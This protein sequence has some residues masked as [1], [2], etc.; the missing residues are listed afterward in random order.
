MEDESIAVLVTGAERRLLE[1]ET[2]RDPA[3]LEDLLHE[4]FREIGRSGRLWTRDELIDVMTGPDAVDVQSAVVTGEHVELVG[5]DLALLTYT[6]DADGMRSRR[7]SLWR[8]T[9]GRPRMLFHQG[10]PLG[11]HVG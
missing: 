2:R 3:A 11:P 6:L 1:P 8:L 9:G 5:P 10:T 7:S 4:S